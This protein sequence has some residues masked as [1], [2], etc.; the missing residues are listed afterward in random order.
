M[1][2]AKLRCIFA[3]FIRNNPEAAE[4]LRRS[5]FDGL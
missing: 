2:G 3:P 1:N 4:A 5:I